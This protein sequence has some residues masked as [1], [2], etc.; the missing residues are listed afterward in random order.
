MPAPI[1]LEPLNSGIKDF[2]SID[3]RCCLSA[4]I[5]SFV[6]LVTQPSRSYQPCSLGKKFCVAASGD[7]LFKEEQYYLFCA[8]L[9]L[10]LMELTQPFCSYAHRVG[11]GERGNKFLTELPTNKKWITDLQLVFTKVLFEFVC[12]LLFRNKISYQLFHCPIDL[13]FY[14]KMPIF[15][16]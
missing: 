3:Q 2:D 13:Y 4:D 5:I 10:D 8:I 14:H 1:Q 9:N 6:W 16:F 7:N 15:I 11:A 12:C